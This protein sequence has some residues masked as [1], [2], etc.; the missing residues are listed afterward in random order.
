M[1]HFGELSPVP[2]AGRALLWGG[3]L[4]RVGNPEGVFLAK[5][6]LTKAR[7]AGASLE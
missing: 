6:L 7:T 1:G 3:A 2:G 4:W 5:N